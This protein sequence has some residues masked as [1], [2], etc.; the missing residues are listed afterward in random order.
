[1]LAQS[2]TKPFIGTTDSNWQ[3]VLFL[4]TSYK[5]EIGPQVASTKPN[6][7]VLSFAEGESFRDAWRPH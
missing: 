6:I 3:V 4:R 7:H 2:Y 5:P 1:M